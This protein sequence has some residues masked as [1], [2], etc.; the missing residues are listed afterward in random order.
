MFV[1][2]HLLSLNSLSVRSVRRRQNHPTDDGNSLERWYLSGVGEDITWDGCAPPPDY[3]I[4][5]ESG[6][7][8]GDRPNGDYVVAYTNRY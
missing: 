6:R 3:D 4:R 8:N 7:P 1:T 2:K 5:A